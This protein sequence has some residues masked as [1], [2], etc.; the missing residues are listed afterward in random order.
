MYGNLGSIDEKELKVAM[1]ALGFGSTKA[2][3][4]GATSVPVV[5]DDAVFAAEPKKDEIQKMIADVDQ[6]GDGEIDF[7]E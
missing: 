4:S 3:S 1:R 2:Q 5:N 6:T 7:D